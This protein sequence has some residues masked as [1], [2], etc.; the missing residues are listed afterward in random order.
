M[1]FGANN[2]EPHTV[3]RI[4]VYTGEICRR[5]IYLTREYPTIFN[6]RPDKK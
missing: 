3:P 1:D 5:L 2:V 4:S 6:V